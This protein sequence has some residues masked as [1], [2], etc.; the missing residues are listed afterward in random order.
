MY[1]FSDVEISQAIFKSY[2]SKFGQALWSDVVLVG[3]G[4]S[5]LVAAWHLARANF[6]VVVLE[7]RLSPGGGIWGGSI[8]MN[9][10]VVQKQALDILSEAGVRFRP[11]GRL[12]TADA[13]ELASALC[14]KALHA[15]ATILNLMTVEDLCVRNGRVTGVVANRSLIGENLPVD[16]IA[17][18]T[19][20]VIDATGHEAAVAGF[21]QRRGLLKSNQGQ[22]PGE[23]PMDAPSGERFVEETVTEI[24]PGLWLTGMS[25]CASLGGPRMGPIFGGMLLSG[26]KAADLVGLSLG[27]KPRPSE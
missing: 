10:I 5:G 23:G 3:A 14:L 6:N 12:F 16:P 2:G 9:E 22:L 20:A 13:M 25:V 7:K 15:G 24:Y 18:S 17:F 11:S 19:R 8:G 27:K 4:P 21:L 1:D 26:I